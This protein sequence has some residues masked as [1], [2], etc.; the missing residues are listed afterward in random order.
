MDVRI[1]YLLISVVVPD[2]L[3]SVLLEDLEVV[4][5]V[6]VG[7]DRD[8]GEDGRGL[9]HDVGGDVRGEGEVPVQALTAW[10]KQGQMFSDSEFPF[11]ILIM[12]Q[13][14]ARILHH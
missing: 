1:P 7:A 8:G 12:W 3:V 4:G 11:Y 5:K 13:H 9:V 2:W 10:D 6:L 14:F